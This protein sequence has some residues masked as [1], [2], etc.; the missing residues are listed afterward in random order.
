TTMSDIILLLVVVLPFITGFIA[1]HQWLAYQT[2]LTL[3]VLCGEI[4]L[5]VIPFTRLSHMLY[6]FFT[7]AFM[8]CEFGAIRNARDW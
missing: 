5:I 8:G 1:H 3:H 2:M 7:R 6:F 4:M